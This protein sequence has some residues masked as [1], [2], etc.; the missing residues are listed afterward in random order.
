[1]TPRSVSVAPRTPTWL[2]GA[3]YSQPVLSRPAGSSSSSTRAFSG[4]AASSFMNQ[5]QSP[6]CSLMDS[7]RP[8]APILTTAAAQPDFILSD[9]LDASSRGM[10]SAGRY[11]QWAGGNGTTAR[12]A[13][14]FP[15]SF[16]CPAAMPL[17]RPWAYWLVPAGARPACADLV[18]AQTSAVTGPMRIL[19]VSP[20][21]A[22]CIGGSER[23]LQA[24]SE[25]LVARGHAVTVLTLDCATQRD[26]TSGTGAGLPSGDLLNGVKVIRV[27]PSGGGLLHA[28]EWWLRRRGGW[29]STRWLF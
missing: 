2:T 28:V 29:R 15:C 1:M 17:E 11:V 7:G 3:A 12:S 24:V 8:F 22:P 23:M 4:K 19:H 27:S 20:T 16:C 6:M 9:F 14:A 26:L 18:D 25:R 5:W 21:Y 13:R 10:Y